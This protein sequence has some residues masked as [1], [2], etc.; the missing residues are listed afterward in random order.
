MGSRSVVL[1]LALLALAPPCLARPGPRPAPGHRARS[2][3]RAAQD[4]PPKWGAESATATR[5]AALDSASCRDALTRRGVRF[6]AVGQAPGVETP[7]R[8]VGTLNGV[9]YRTDYPDSQRESVPFEIF[10]CRL[11]LALLELDPILKAHSIEEVRIYSAWRPPTGTRVP[12]GPTHAHPAGLAVDIRLF[13]KSSGEELE[14]ERD[15]HGTLGRD[16]CAP[17]SDGPSEGPARELREIYCGAA[18]AQLFHVQL[19][20]D[21][22]ERHHNHFHLE[23]R[24]GVR[25]FIV[26]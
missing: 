6:R 18:A 2:A 8:L 11:V 1:A 20:P 12:P 25:W 9:K 10:D 5:I 17:A 7:V 22:D 4:P 21:H 15:F 19:S 26:R 3:P 23:V 14:I 16:P 13:R 24:P